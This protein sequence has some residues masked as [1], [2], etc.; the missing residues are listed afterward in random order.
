MDMNKTIEY[1][2]KLLRGSVTAIGA[3]RNRERAAIKTAGTALA[4]TAAG[5]LVVA[6]LTSP[7]AS[8]ADN[9]DEIRTFTI[10]VSQIGSTNAQNDV[11]PAEGDQTFSRGD[12]FI[13]RGTIYPKHTLPPGKAENDPTAPGIGKYEIRGTYTAGPEASIIAFATELFLLPD[14]A[15]SILIDGLWPNEGSSAHRPVLGGTGRFRYAA[16][17]AIEENLGRNKDGF[18]NL[19]VTFRLRKTR[20]GR[21]DH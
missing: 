15:S 21:D 16:G 17:E 7:P 10:D 4:L 2:R 6:G 13:I 14:D 5:I 12:T 20:G 1:G 19:R 18:C 11:D 3:L 9:D 8:R